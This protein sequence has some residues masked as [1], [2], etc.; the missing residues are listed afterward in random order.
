MV[1]GW[2]T[3]ELVDAAV[4]FVQI[5]LLDSETQTEES[6]VRGCGIGPLVED[7]EEDAVVTLVRD[8]MVA[9]L[10]QGSLLGFV[11][12]AILVLV[13]IFVL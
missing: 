11:L 7:V 4:F 10:C 8:A 2:L 3:G 6:V 1:G 9:R 13:A 5:S 12:V